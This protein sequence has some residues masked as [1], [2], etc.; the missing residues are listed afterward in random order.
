MQRE[1]LDM[2]AK[3]KALL[4]KMNAVT[5]Q[6][7]EPPTMSNPAAPQPTA[8]SAKAPP[9]LPPQPAATTV[10]AATPLPAAGSMSGTGAGG[11]SL[12][13]DETVAAAEVRLM[14]HYDMSSEERDVWF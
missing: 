6:P 11:S 13:E 4:E 12:P 9:A 2:Q 10:P 5:L 1:L 14:E 8:P 3:Y 7:P